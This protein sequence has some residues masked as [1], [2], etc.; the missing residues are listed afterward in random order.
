MAGGA[1]TVAA[2]RARTARAALT[3]RTDLRF[4]GGFFLGFRIAF[5]E[6]LVFCHGGLRLFRLASGAVGAGK[7][8]VEAAVAIEREGFDE[9][10]NGF[11]R[12]AGAGQREAERGI[13][14]EQ[15]GVAGERGFEMRDRLFGPLQAQEAI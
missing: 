10:R 3:R 15:L 2:A 6:L 4:T 13:R 14:G 12:L 5:A 8:E 9:V 1:G 7:L 11:G